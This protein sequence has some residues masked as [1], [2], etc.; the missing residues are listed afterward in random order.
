M[1][2]RARRL[3]V[4]LNNTAKTSKHTIVH[5]LFYYVTIYQFG[6]NE[7]NAT[8]PPLVMLY[9]NVSHPDS[10]APHTPYVP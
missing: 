4:F 5:V 7:S 2:I 9:K 1:V 6:N 10:M 8:E 3:N